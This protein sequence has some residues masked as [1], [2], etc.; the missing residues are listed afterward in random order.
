MCMIWSARDSGK[1]QGGLEFLH[2]GQHLLGPANVAPFA[3]HLHVAIKVL[4]QSDGWTIYAGSFCSVRLLHLGGSQEG[5]KRES[6]RWS[7]GQEPLLVHRVEMLRP[8]LGDPL[9]AKHFAIAFVDRF[10]LSA[11]PRGR[12]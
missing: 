3:A 5:I 12:S 8:A 7:A 1:P 10:R 9:L 11:S 2:F 4:L 6:G